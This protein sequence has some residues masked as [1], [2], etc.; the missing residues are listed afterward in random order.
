VESNWKL[1]GDRFHLTVT[2]PANSVATVYVPAHE[3][4]DVTESGKSIAKAKGVKSVRLENGRAVIEVGS[5]QYTFVSRPNL[6]AK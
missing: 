5:G 4:T 2:I 3:T 1:E 6:K